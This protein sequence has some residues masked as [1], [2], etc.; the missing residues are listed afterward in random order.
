MLKNKIHLNGY[1]FS[2]HKGVSHCNIPLEK[3][4]ELIGQFPILKDQV[5]YSYYYYEEKCILSDHQRDCFG[6]K[7]KIFSI[8]N[9]I[10]LVHPEDL[11]EVYRLTSNAFDTL[12]AHPESLYA[13]KYNI[14][15]RI[16]DKTNGYRR[17]LRET[18]PLLVDSYG[19]LVCTL[20]RCTDITHLGHHREIKAWVSCSGKVID[21]SKEFNNILT[22]REKEILYYLSKGF[23]SRKISDTLSISKLTIDKHRA[24][25]LR[26]TRANNTSELIKFAYEKGI[27]GL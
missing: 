6:Y 25:M 1:T 22:K 5:V 10:D 26:K 23:S 9:I 17:V 18:T 7:D 11:D 27:L 21:L 13:F 20:S 2:D 16:K 15:Y 24:N 19:K 8:T 4:R 3:I 12:Y 14:A